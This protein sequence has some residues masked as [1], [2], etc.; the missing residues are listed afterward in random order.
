MLERLLN[1]DDDDDTI[2]R[3]NRNKGNLRKDDDF[4]GNDDDGDDGDNGVIIDK[5]IICDDLWIRLW[6][7]DDANCW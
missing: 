5:V 4:D 2:G 3:W 6:C 7:N 1:D